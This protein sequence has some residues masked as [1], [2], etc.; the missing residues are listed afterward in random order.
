MPPQHLPDPAELI[1]ELVAERS[2][3]ASRATL[4]DTFFSRVRQVWTSGVTSAARVWPML[5]LEAHPGLRKVLLWSLALPLFGGVAAFGIAPG[6]ATDGLP[7]T[8]V[9]ST[10]VLPAVTPTQTTPL[11]FWREERIARGDTLASLLAR[12]EV[13][14]GDIQRSLQAARQVRTLRSLKPGAPVMARVTADGQLLLLRHLLGDGQLL[15]LQRQGDQIVGQQVKA[16][17]ETRTIMR[18]GIVQSSLYAAMDDANVPDSIT[19]R[20]AEIFSG[21]IDFHREL[22]IGDRFAVIFEARYYAGQLVETGN[23]LAAEYLNGN[24]LYQ[25]IRFGDTYY[26]V[27]GRSLK[28]A[29]L[30]SPIA[31]ARV[32]SRFSKARYHPVLKEWRAHRG[33]DYAAPTGTPIRAT[34]DGRVQF[35]GQKGGYG[36]LVVLIHNGQYSTAYGHLSRFAKGLRSGGRVQQ[37]QLIGYVGQTGLAT[38]PHLHYEFRVNGM[39]RDPLALKLPTSV[40]LAARQ[41]AAFKLAA[42][43]LAD[44]LRLIRG[45]NLAALD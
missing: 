34:A 14:A 10:V 9:S 23:I 38:G 7:R 19:V 13:N 40:P 24:T 27:E 8:T 36:K 5:C 4:S 11:D 44:Q 32:S 3:S 35:V 45:H 20:L 6:T 42:A 25:A 31:F 12:L 29:F 17:L 41:R 43:P 33:I 15:T 16:Q 26:N 2:V 21:E 18:S 28:R 30:K 1:A 37:G 39:Q 22:K